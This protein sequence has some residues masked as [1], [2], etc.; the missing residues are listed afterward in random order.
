MV[1]LMGVRWLFSSLQCHFGAEIERSAARSL[2]AYAYVRS[3]HVRRSGSTGDGGPEGATG[4]GF[5]VM[6]QVVG[7]FHRENDWKILGKTLGK[8]LGNI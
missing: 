7:Y 2:N 5:G 1:F 3:R 6:P 8:L 4:R